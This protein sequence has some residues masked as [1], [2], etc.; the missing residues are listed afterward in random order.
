MWPSEARREGCVQSSLSI[1][2]KRL[3]AGRLNGFSGDTHGDIYIYIY[4]YKESI[5]PSCRAQPSLG[6]FLIPMVFVVC[7]VVALVFSCV[8]LGRSLSLDVLKATAYKT[9][10]NRSIL[11]TNLQ[12][13]ELSKRCLNALPLDAC[14]FKRVSGVKIL[15]FLGMFQMICSMFRCALA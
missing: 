3:S 7:G 1:F 2:S 5:N 12:N 4:I 14:R 13:R 11:L 15:E 6:A 9:R 8:F 10:A